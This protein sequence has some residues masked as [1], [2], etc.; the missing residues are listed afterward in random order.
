MNNVKQAL[1]GILIIFVVIIVFTLID[2]IVGFSKFNKL[3]DSILIYNNQEY[4]RV[5]SWSVDY[6]DYTEASAFFGKENSK[7]KE[8]NTTVKVINGTNDEFVLIKFDKVD[9][10]YHK[11][12]KELPSYLDSDKVDSARITIDEKHH[13]LSKDMT[14]KI[15]DYLGKYSF[16]W[17]LSDEN[18][19]IEHL[20]NVKVT[21]SQYKGVSQLIGA[22]AIYQNN[23]VFIPNDAKDI[24]FATELAYTGRCFF[25]AFPFNPL[26]D[27]KQ[28]DERILSIYSQDSLRDSNIV[29]YKN[30]IYRHTTTLVPVSNKGKFVDAYYGKENSNDKTDNKIVYLFDNCDEEFIRVTVDKIERIYYLQDAAVPLIEDQNRIEKIMLVLDDGEKVLDKNLYNDFFNH[31]KESKDMCYLSLVDLENKKIGDVIVRF[32]DSTTAIK[33]GEVVYDTQYTEDSS[34]VKKVC[35]YDTSIRKFEDY[36]WVYPLPQNIID[37]INQTQ[38]N[39]TNYYNQVTVL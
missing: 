1:K 15:Q 3:N 9:V 16:G 8:P 14:Q 37:S 25:I 20:T 17:I 39:Q 23:I 11:K 26:D 33:L 28:V 19:P 31:I 5:K 21:Y 4:E 38:T 36:R 22:F 24:P 2:L 12:D 32:K 18:I 27:F 35:F 34:A 13:Y 29:V 6:Y 10:L 7:N 30:K